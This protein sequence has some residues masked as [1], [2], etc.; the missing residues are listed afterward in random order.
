MG[1]NGAGETDFLPLHSSAMAVGRRC[2]V[3]VVVAVHDADIDGAVRLVRGDDDVAN[4]HFVAEAKEH[5]GP[6]RD[7]FVAFFRGDAGEL[8]FES[9]AAAGDLR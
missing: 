9:F 6:G 7:S 4:L 3:E 2:R 5:A 8:G 1:E